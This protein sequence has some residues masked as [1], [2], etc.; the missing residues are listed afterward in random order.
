MKNHTPSDLLSIIVPCYNEESG[1]ANTIEVLVRT[2]NGTDIPY[3]LIFVNDG[4]KDRT[5]DVIVEYARQDPVHIKGLSFSRNF[6]KEA[7]MLAG[8]HFANGACA[9]LIDSD[10]QHPPALI[11]EMYQLY[12]D[13]F[14]IVE[15][16][17]KQ[18]QSE[19][20]V[21]RAFAKIFYFL[22][23]YA[24]GMDVENAS[25]FKLISRRVMDVLLSM[26]EKERFFRGLTFWTGLPHVM[27]PYTVQERSAGE[28]KWSYRKLIKYA[29]QNII[30]FSALPLHFISVIGGIMLLLGI[31]FGIRA[32]RLYFC[33]LAAGGITTL[34]MLIMT[35]SGL[36]LVSLSII[37]RYLASIYTELK[38]RPMYLVERTAGLGGPYDMIADTQAIIDR[39]EVS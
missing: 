5:F 3:E 11:P 20:M 23:N 24:I 33:G 30:S 19:T 37:G 7:A 25:D 22:F 39:G 13:G 17:K 21:H 8:I 35:A 26:P 10:L 18:R 2:M 28:S 29:I 36:I 27:L 32:L 6:G 34:V 9:V 12:L 15:G 14:D 4:S 31:I 1:L 38:S 16:V